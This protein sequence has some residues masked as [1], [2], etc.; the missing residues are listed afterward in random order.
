[1]GGP[2]AADRGVSARTVAS[3]EEAGLLAVAR[4]AARAA[5]AEL[6]A[7]YDAAP[8]GVGTK[9]TATD[10]VSAADLAA[11]AAIRAVLAERRPGD[12]VLGEEGG[13][14]AGADPGA[15]ATGVRWVVDP[16]DGTVNYLFGYPQWSVSVACEDAQGTI[17]GVVLDPLRDEEVAATRSGPLLRD[18]VAWERGRGA[19]GLEVALVATGFGYDASVRAR[20]ADVVR[21]VIPRVRDVRRGGS[22]ALDLA[23]TALGRCDAYYERARAP[24]SSFTSCRQIRPRALRPACSSRR[25]G[26]PKGC[27]RSSAS[28]RL[29]DPHRGGGGTADAVASK[30]TV[31]KD[32]RVRLPPAPSPV[33]RGRAGLAHQRRQRLGGQHEGR[34]D[35]HADAL[36]GKPTRADDRDSDK[37][38]LG[39]VAK[40]MPVGRLVEVHR[41]RRVAGAEVQDVGLAVVVDA[42]EVGGG[43]R[44][45][46]GNPRR[47]NA[48]T[49]N[50]RS[51]PKATT[52][53]SHRLGPAPR[54]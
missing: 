10:L 14:T 1:V 21:R 4:A 52:T 29:R 13:E 2:P 48:V 5:A 49:T 35:P 15:E 11:E 22:A 39:V 28:R 45:A 54:R 24:G 32:V 50:P 8:E 53:F 12:A 23:W 40:C 6:L 38:A 34:R 51:S 44:E 46:H 30:A 33:L 25:R 41:V 7:R 42:I 37:P 47:A 19:A 20:Q 31:R 26:S 17:A 18:G 36:V 9:T 27:S 3:A 43:N 16:L